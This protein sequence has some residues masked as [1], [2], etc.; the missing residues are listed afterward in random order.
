[1]R[2]HTAFSPAQF[3]SASSPALRR[4]VRAELLELLRREPA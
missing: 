4:A 1:V 2:L 3:V